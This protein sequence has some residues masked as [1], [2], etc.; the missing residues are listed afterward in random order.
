MTKPT[1]E[2]REEHEGIRLMLKILE[3]VCARIASK[4]PVS[5][6]HLQNTVE[7]IEIFIDKCHHGKEEDLLFPEMMK[8]GVPKERGPIGVMLMEHDRGRQFV[9]QMKE[10][11]LNRN[12]EQAFIENA[13]NYIDLLTEHMEKENNVLFPMAENVLSDDQKNALV[14]GFEKLERERI[15]EGRHEEFHK[16]LQDLKQIYLG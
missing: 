4:R 11:L 10:S 1:D 16:L 6:E 14:R 12:L 9:K 15:G 2:L 5:E 3:E 8:A 13:R 7:F